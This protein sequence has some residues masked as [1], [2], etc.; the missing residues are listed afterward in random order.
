MD[1][2]AVITTKKGSHCGF[3]EGFATRSWAARLMADFLK[4]Y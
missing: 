4:N 3:Y 1:N 2:I